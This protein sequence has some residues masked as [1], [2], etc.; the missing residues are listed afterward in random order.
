MQIVELHHTLPRL[1]SAYSRLISMKM[2][3]PRYEFDTL[4]DA[5]EQKYNN[6][7]AAGVLGSTPI[8]RSRYEIHISR[9]SP[10]N[11]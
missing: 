9:G 7:G 10:Y 4:C 1:I 11:K 8:E 2:R 5:P 6:P 3:F